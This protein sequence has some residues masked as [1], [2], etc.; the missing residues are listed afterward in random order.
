MTINR[1]NQEWKHSRQELLAAE[2]LT[3]TSKLRLSRAYVQPDSSQRSCPWNYSRTDF[4]NS[5]AN[6]SHVLSAF[7]SPYPG[8]MNDVRCAQPKVS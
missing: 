5:L 6:A 8:M 1:S 7:I 4:G 3:R 2:T